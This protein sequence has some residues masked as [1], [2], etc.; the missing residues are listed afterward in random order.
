MRNSFAQLKTSSEETVEK[1]FLIPITFPPPQLLAAFLSQWDPP[2]EKA[3]TSRQL[4]EQQQVY[5]STRHIAV[6]IL[7]ARVPV[8]PTLPCPD[9]PCFH[10]LTSAATSPIPVSDCSHH[11]PSHILQHLF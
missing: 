8:F 5:L 6:M 10:P 11:E 1:T 2:C 3:K 4:Q 7:Q 9:K